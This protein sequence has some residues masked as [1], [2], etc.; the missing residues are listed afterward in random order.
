[1]FRNIFEERANFYTFDK[2]N[3]ISKEYAEE[4]GQDLVHLMEDKQL[5]DYKTISACVALIKQGASVDVR[6]CN[7]TTPLMY[8]AEADCCD[9][10]T[11]ICNAN[12]EN[13][14]TENINARNI[15]GWTAL[16][17]AA[18][19]GQKKA[20]KLLLSYGADSTLKTPPI[21]GHMA[22]RT[23][24]T[25]AQDRGYE[26][27]AEVIRVHRVTHAFE[28]AANQGTTRARKVH[29]APSPAIRVD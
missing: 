5:D 10:I 8:A 19:Y 15:N 17:H 18:H 20:V 24:E 22:P 4:L 11:V 21:K 14:N 27:I 6:G 9:I 2:L 16:M 25:I 7:R 13:A 29:R 23:A 1:M 12:D 3:K 28:T 26:D